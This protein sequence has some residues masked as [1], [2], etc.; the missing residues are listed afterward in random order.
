MKFAFAQTKYL[1][2]GVIKTERFQNFWMYCQSIGR[3]YTLTM[4]CEIPPAARSYLAGFQ[5][6]VSRTGTDG[7]RGV[8]APRP[9]V[10]GPYRI[11]Q[12][13][14]FEVF[15]RLRAIERVSIEF[16]KTKTNVITLANQKG[17][18]QSR[19]PNQNSKQLHVANTMRGK[20]C[21]REP[22]LVLVSLL[23]G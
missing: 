16:R 6:H 15:I 20:M 14:S 8:S 10:T 23:I 17:R 13:S 19:K 7:G 2:H 4:H 5:V 9:Y 22:R 3:T 12:L 1:R 18:R 11:G 21:T